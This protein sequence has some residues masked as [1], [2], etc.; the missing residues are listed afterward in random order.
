PKSIEFGVDINCGQTVG[1]VH[2]RQLSPSGHE[3]S[4][5]NLARG[6]FHKAIA[7][8]SY[9]NFVLTTYTYFLSLTIL[10]T[11]HQQNNTPLSTVFTHDTTPVVSQ[12]V[13]K[14]QPSHQ[15]LHHFSHTLIDSLPNAVK[16]LAYLQ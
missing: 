2:K 14:P 9:P 12:V 6:Q 3:T 1:D 7:S 10:Y 15:T 11:S 13:A 4:G 16:Y 5:A 8:S